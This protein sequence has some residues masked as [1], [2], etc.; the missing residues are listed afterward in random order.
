MN[1]E[2]NYTVAEQIT[3]LH[4]LF[5]K[6]E[7]A[8][9]KLKHYIRYCALH[10]RRLDDI[11]LA[12][13]QSEERLQLLKSEPFY[14]PEPPANIALFIKS[15]KVHIDS[16]MILNIV[17][18]ECLISLRKFQEA[19]DA[20]KTDMDYTR[21]LQ[22][23]RI[24]MLA[25]KIN[26]I[27]YIHILNNSFDSYWQAL[28]DTFMINKLHYYLAQY[29]MSQY[30]FNTIN[31]ICANDAFLAACY[32][33]G[34]YKNS[35]YDNKGI[36]KRILTVMNMCHFSEHTIAKANDILDIICNKSILEPDKIESP[37][38]KL[39][40]VAGLWHSGAFAIHDYLAGSRDCCAPFLNS[41][42]SLFR[43]D[44][45]IYSLYE[46]LDKEINIFRKELLKVF[47][48]QILN[49][50]LASDSLSFYLHHLYA[51]SKFYAQSE[52]SYVGYLGWYEEFC[53]G[54]LYAH[55]KKD[56]SL[57]HNA[58]GCF[59]NN[60]ARPHLIAENKHIV[61]GN[62]INAR[63]AARLAAT[64]TD[65]IFVVCFRN[66]KDQY[67]SGAEEMKLSKFIEYEKSLLSSLETSYRQLGSTYRF[68][69]VSY[70]AFVKS[71]AYRDEFAKKLNIDNS[72][73]GKPYFDPDISIK[74][75]GKHK[76]HPDQASIQAAATSLPQL[77]DGSYMKLFAENFLSDETAK[78]LI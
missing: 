19:I 72:T 12:F 27:D 22:A 25:S 58:A 15:L 77:M 59:V 7:I 32:A 36:A 55:A 24:L 10:N 64:P 16:A 78:E 44:I 21:R 66:P 3:I 74:N 31:A 51:I 52:E 5:L 71:K 61:L 56:I 49:I 29:E 9:Q 13:S 42:I 4:S 45:D 54:A 47:L 53:R 17:I 37:Q 60:L 18:Q 68:I 30:D 38:C 28:T 41:E 20:F 2:K 46:A 62:A 33:E 65:S 6:C 48:Y 67:C 73:D 35:I 75:I 23:W 63:L 76:N 40:F 1:R 39:I 26:F 14:M 34:I 70:E 43:Q 69:P 8:P 57:F 11:V 50:K